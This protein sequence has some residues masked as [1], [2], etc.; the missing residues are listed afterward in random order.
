MSDLNDR[1]VFSETASGVL[2]AEPLGERVV[3]NALA[4]SERGEGFP[5]LLSSSVCYIILEKVL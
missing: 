3:E 1:Q 4:R 2:G 5:L